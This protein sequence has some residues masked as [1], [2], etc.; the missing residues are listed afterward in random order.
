MAFLFDKVFFFESVV[1]SLEN[2]TPTANCTAEKQMHVMDACF[3]PL[4]LI[5]TC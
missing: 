2:T 1:L 3:W 5:T 4:P